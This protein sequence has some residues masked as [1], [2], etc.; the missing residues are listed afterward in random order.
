MT[1]VLKFRRHRYGWYCRPGGLIKRRK[2]DAKGRGGALE[3]MSWK[4]L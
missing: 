1:V 3:K 4:R 2:E